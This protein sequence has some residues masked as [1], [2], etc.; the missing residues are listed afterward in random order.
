MRSGH[1]AIWNVL[2]QSGHEKSL[3]LLSNTVKKKKKA[4]I[5]LSGNFLLV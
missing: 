4:P 1:A 2:Y 3:G 5:Y